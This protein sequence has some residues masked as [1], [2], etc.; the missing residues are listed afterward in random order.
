MW[1]VSKVVVVQQECSHL[2][3]GS[4]ADADGGFQA[5]LSQLATNKALQKSMATSVSK[6][7]Q[8][9]L[10]QEHGCKNP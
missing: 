5:G 9:R 7:L 10:A 2:T 8:A 6:H 3:H 4:F 1:D